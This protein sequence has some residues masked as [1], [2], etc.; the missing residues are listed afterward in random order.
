MAKIEKSVQVKSMESCIGDL[1]P[2]WT[3]WPWSE[4]RC[5]PLEKPHSA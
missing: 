3:N 4:F 5:M 2:F 1:N